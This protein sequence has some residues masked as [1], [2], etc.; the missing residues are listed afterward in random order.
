VGQD[1]AEQGLQLPRLLL[2][3][4]RPTTTN[5]GM[6]CYRA[7]VFRDPPLRV[8]C[9][10]SSR[11]GPRRGFKVGELAIT[12]RPRKFG[13]SKYG[14]RRFVKGVL[15]LLTVKFLTATPAPATRPRPSAWPAFCSATAPWP[16]SASP[17]SPSLRPDA[18]PPLHE[19]ALLPYALAAMLVGAQMMTWGPGRVDPAYQGRDGDTYSIAECVGDLRRPSNRETS[20]DRFP[21]DVLLSLN[22]GVGE[23]LARDHPWSAKPAAM[24]GVRACQGAGVSPAGE[25]LDRPTEFITVHVK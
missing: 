9:T 17:G 16:G 7:E 19:R 10:A 11:A 22:D 23:P 2:T 15:D 8:N 18:F 21:P 12:H 3:G 6:K 20:R 5:C 13:A 24:A 1:A 4:V 14:V 25:R